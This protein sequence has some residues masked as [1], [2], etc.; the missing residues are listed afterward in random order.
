MGLIHYGKFTTLQLQK[1]IFQ[2]A[3]NW[4]IYNLNLRPS[5]K[6]NS[7]D[8][9]EMYSYVTLEDV[10]WNNNNLLELFRCPFYLMLLDIKSIILFSITLIQ[11][12]KSWCYGNEPPWKLKLFNF[13]ILSDKR[14]TKNIS[15]YIMQGF[16]LTENVPLLSLSSEW[17]LQSFRDNFITPSQIFSSD[18]VDNLETTLPLR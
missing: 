4:C 7:L 12:R 16:V 1:V 10:S 18:S 3:E 11:Q 13:V 2:Y 14:R 8:R 5:V 9:G 15:K 6:L 17:L